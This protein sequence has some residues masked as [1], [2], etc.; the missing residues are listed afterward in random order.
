VRVEL[1]IEGLVLPEVGLH[2]DPRRAA[3]AAFVSHAHADHLGAWGS[4]AVYASRETIALME[5]RR[6]PDVTLHAR[7]LEWGETIELGGAKISLAP[8]G[9]V[10]GAAQLV[11]DHA[12]GRSVYTGDYRTG[13]G[14]THAEGK[15]VPC[16]E[17]L[18][19]ST[20]ALPIFK[21]PD[22]ARA[23]ADL[24]MWCKARLSEGE[25][26]VVLAYV[27]GKSQELIARLLAEEVPLAAHGAIYN[28]CQV[29]ESL[30]HGMG[31]A[32]GRLV[33]YADYKEKKEPRVVVV[34]PGAHTR[35]F[36]GGAK[37][38]YVSGWALLDAAVEQRRA[39]AAFV[40]SD[41][42]DHDDLVATAKATGAR[43]VIATLGDAAPLAHILR[44]HGVHASAIDLP[45]IDESMPEVEP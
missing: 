36:K 6:P 19:E 7:P 5:R 11:V 20:F 33:T 17:L 31:V 37:I 44:R 30:G 40:I 32:D 23:M 42:A 43:H 18:I 10:L 14:L 27:L 13:P 8:A 24:V 16:D 1:T 28:M 15:P 41:H 39:D 38:A 2:L 29:Y 34:P 21:W 25:T 35:M 26:P 22:R 45:S 4:E 12:G 9:H 3:P